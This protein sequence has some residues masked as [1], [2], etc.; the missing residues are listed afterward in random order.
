M[1]SIIFVNV[2]AYRILVMRILSKE[3]IVQFYTMNKAIKA[4]ELA[5]VAHS[6]HDLQVPV[7]VNLQTAHGSTLFMP[8]ATSAACGCK[9]VCV[10]PE[11]R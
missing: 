11:N 10:R 6:N 2:F 8:G 9:I 4:T 7:R 1:L 3:N 5:F